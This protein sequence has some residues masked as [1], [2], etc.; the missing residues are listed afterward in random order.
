MKISKSLLFITLFSYFCMFQYAL[1][2]SL[3]R[4]YDDLTT[5]QKNTWKRLLHYSN[6]ESV[7][8]LPST[9]FVS[10]HGNV[11]PKMEY[12][13]TYKLFINNEV[14]QCKFP[15]RY[16]F[17]NK[18]LSVNINNCPEFKIHKD[19][20]HIDNV[21][22]VVAA[23]DST[24]PVSAM[25]HG[26]IMIEVTNAFNQGVR[27]VINYGAEDPV[28]QNPFKVIQ[29]IMENNMSGAYF[30]ERYDDCIY[31]YTTRD[32]RSLWEYKLNLSG[33]EIALL[34]DHLF[35]LKGHQIGYSIINNNCANGSEMFL[36]SASEKFNSN[37]SLFITPI[38]YSQFLYDNQLITDDISIRPSNSDKYALDHGYLGMPLITRKPSRIDFS[39]NHGKYYDFGELSFSPLFKNIN[40]DNLGT[41]DIANTE[42]FKVTL[43]Y[44]YRRSKL[45]IKNID[46]L[47][48]ALYSNILANN[49]LSKSINISFTGNNDDKHSRLYPELLGGLGYSIYLSDFRPYVI[50]KVGTHFI[51]D[52]VLGIGGEAGFFIVNNHIGRIHA[53]Y[54]QIYAGHSY[55]HGA[56]YETNLNWSKL[57]FDNFSLNLKYKAFKNKNSNEFENYGSL[58]F[59]Y[60]F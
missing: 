4:N 36:N 55:W 30:L 24:N 35:E 22:Y 16:S 6:D 33:D 47:N 46:L 60:T 51:N 37:S 34:E 41:T 14:M 18:G 25:G 59:V 1:A 12:E 58:G 50:A 44:D 17:I 10:S 39:T 28:N 40:D 8:R 42:F 11:N 45:F 57:I 27:Y 38:S 43:N 5:K 3:P 19:Y 52:T 20:I 48:L 29:K 9:F 21:Y 31:N 54:E 2:E 15:S 7:I 56:Q 23:E 13:E 49:N 32:D 26:F 53:S